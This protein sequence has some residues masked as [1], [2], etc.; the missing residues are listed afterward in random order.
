MLGRN[1]E[2]IEQRVEILKSIILFKEVEKSILVKMAK[3][4][5]PKKIEKDEVL[6]NKGDHDYAL[7]IVVEG[8]VKAHVGSHT[9]ATFGSLQYFGEYSLLDS[10]A[11]STTVTAVETSKLLRLDQSVF[12]KFLDTIPS[13]SRAMLTGLVWRLRDYNILEAELT[14]KNLE[15]KKQK[16]VLELH[17]KELE[18]LNQTKDKFFA[19]IAHDLRNPFST[20]LSL[21]ELL[22]KEFDTFEPDKMQLFIEQIYKYSN[23]TF[24]LLENLLQWSLLQT[25]RTVLRAKSGN[26]AELI[27]E[28]IEL[29]KGNAIQKKIELK[30]INPM[31]CYAFFDRNMITTVIRNLISNAIK[32]TPENGRIIVEVT[33][34]PEKYKV[35]VQDNGVGIS[36]TD[37]AK[38][39]RIDSN[40]STIGTS[41]EQGTGLGLILCRDFV[42]KNGGKIAV[43]SEVG[44]GS[45]FYF[46]VPRFES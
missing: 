9:F 42:E 17:R 1:N 20:V 27:H 3:E 10:S 25:G 4:L 29:L 13:L 15:I 44:K 7:Y 11:R 31:D 38:L 32:F 5:A 41:Q 6:F 26:I 36:D 46:T 37:I 28:N 35:S 33:A 8:K 30:W 39:F 34:D 21:S 40:P 22:A 24:N 43:E 18:S 12:F 14:S 2:E 16:E 23:N 19:I 45:R